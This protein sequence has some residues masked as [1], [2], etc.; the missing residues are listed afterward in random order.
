[1][2]DLSAQLFAAFEPA[3]SQNKTATFGCHAGT[4]TVTAGANQ[5]RGLKCALH[6]SSPVLRL[7]PIRPD[8]G[9][10]DI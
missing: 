6:R 2:L 10:A 4:K 3:C 5:V 9:T 8:S 1:M 7:G